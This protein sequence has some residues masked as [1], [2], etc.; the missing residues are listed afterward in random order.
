MPQNKRARKPKAKKPRGAGR[1]PTTLQV[2]PQ[3]FSKVFLTYVAKGTLTEPAA[4]TGNFNTFRLNSVY[5]PDFTGVG[6]TAIGFANLSTMY[7][8]YRVLRARVIARVFLT[9]TG[10]ATAGLLPGLNSTY[11]SNL[12]LW[13]GQ[14]HA[15]SKM[16]QA[17][18]GGARAIAD[19]DVT[20]DLPK[21]CGV[22]PSQYRTDMDFSHLSGSNPTKSVFVSVYYLGNAPAVQLAG[23]TIRIIYEVELSQP[24]QTL[25]A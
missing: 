24:L 19:F 18:V 5:D 12:S 22:T 7:G 1:I 11:T 23:Y 17:N 3:A 15:T 2:V 13:E 21:L 20:Y 16:I 14:P 4:S 25:T 9:T 10:C 8:L 6:T